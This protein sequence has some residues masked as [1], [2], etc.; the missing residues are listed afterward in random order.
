MTRVRPATQQPFD[1]DGRTFSP[2]LDGARLAG[3][4]QR[5]REIMRDG[6]WHTLRCLAA[7]TGGS[8][9]GVSARIRDLRKPRFG[10]HAIERRR[11]ADSGLYEYRMVTT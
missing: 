8:E 6:R 9:A 4:L 10:A 11:V 1:F 3:Q 2:T 5:V 7:Q